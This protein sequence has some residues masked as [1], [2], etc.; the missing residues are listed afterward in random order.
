MALPVVSVEIAFESPP[1]GGPVPPVFSNLGVSANPDI[2][3]TSTLSSFANSSWS[4]PSSGLIAVF[5][6]SFRSGGGDPNVPTI[7]GNGLTWVQ[8]ATVSNGTHRLTLFG[9]DASGSTTGAT[10]VSF[11]GQNQDGCKAF[12]MLLDDA[13]LSG[14]VA[15]AFVQAPTGSATD[16]SASITLAAAGNSVNRPISGWAVAGSVSFTPR[17]DWTEMDEITGT[18]HL[19]TQYRS[20]AFDTA[21][22]A[23]W[24]GSSQNWVGIAAEVKGGVAQVTWSDVTPYVREWHVRRGRN[25][26]LDRVQTAEASISFG[27]RGGQ[28]DS[29]KVAGPYYPNVQPGKRMRIRATYSSV[30]Y[31]I[32]NGY[33]ET[34]PQVWSM[35]PLGD[36]EVTIKAADAFKILSLAKFSAVRSAELSGARIGAILDAIG[37]PAADRSI[38]AGISTVQ[39]KTYALDSALSA[40]QEIELTEGG[41]LFMSADGKVTFKDRTK[42]VLDALDTTNYTWGD[43]GSEKIYADLGPLER[44]DTNLWNRIV[45]E[46]PGKTTVDVSDSASRDAFTVAYRTLSLSTLHESQNEMV[47]RANYLLT[48]YGTPKNRISEMVIERSIDYWNRLLDRELHSKLRARKRPV[49]GGTI[50]QDS[51][52][53]GINHDV[54]YRHGT[55]WLVTLNLSPLDEVT[56]YWVLGDTVYS[57]LDSTTRLYY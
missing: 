21:A 6:R 18:G 29:N 28:F 54:D 30:T 26:E 3:S 56:T 27:N 14:G 5:V 48:R 39:A 40:L 37:W 20:D 25:H 52:V 51:F 7:S 19:E 23:T 47:D 22:S 24:G 33:I 44:A 32:F 8:I 11:A 50:E 34:W 53:E 13:D 10:T 12:F 17:T 38:D 45:I 36:A 1:G 16:T 46:A 9:A 57:V 49:G 35:G 41:L 4:P 31:D 15:A 43:L 42:F 55:K 2:S